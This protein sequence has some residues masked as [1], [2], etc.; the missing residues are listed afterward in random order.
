MTTRRPC[1]RDL[2]VRREI[3]AV[4]HQIRRELSEACTAKADQEPPL[5]QQ[6]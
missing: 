5:D 3:D 1:S 6:D 2:T 4:V